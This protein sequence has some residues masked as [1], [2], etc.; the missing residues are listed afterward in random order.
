[1]EKNETRSFL[2]GLF[3]AVLLIASLANSTALEY[4]HDEIIVGQNY[5]TG[6][7]TPTGNSDGATQGYVDSFGFSCTEESVSATACNSNDC[8]PHKATADKVCEDKGYVFASTYIFDN[9][10]S[11]THY[12]WSGS[13]WGVVGTSCFSGGLGVYGGYDNVSTSTPHIIYVECCE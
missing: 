3:V 6:V 10:G 13:S 2:L 7:A 5:V 1:M 4:I 9:Q 8:Y 12:C 11:G